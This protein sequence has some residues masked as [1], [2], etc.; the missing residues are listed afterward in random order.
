MLSCIL[1]LSHCSFVIRVNT[2]NNSGNTSK[3]LFRP[4]LMRTIPARFTSPGTGAHGRRRTLALMQRRPAVSTRIVP[5]LYIPLSKYRS[6]PRDTAVRPFSHHTPLVW[7]T[8]QRRWGNFCATTNFLY[9]WFT[10]KTSVEMTPA[11]RA[12]PLG[13]TASC[14]DSIADTSVWDIFIMTPY[15]SRNIAHLENK[16]SFFISACSKMATTQKTRPWE[17]PTFPPHLWE[18]RWTCPIMRNGNEEQ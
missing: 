1:L 11:L 16:V 15:I 8:A 5:P 6:A 14:G 18:L 3:N 12:Q 10:I 17:F 13:G 9:L 4:G 2:F 7:C